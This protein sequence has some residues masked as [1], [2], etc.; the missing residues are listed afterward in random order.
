MALLR[1][2]C[3]CMASLG[4][5]EGFSLT[6]RCFI[7]KRFWRVGKLELRLKLHPP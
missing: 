1:V 2:L 3:N 5:W 7:H 6:M 4:T